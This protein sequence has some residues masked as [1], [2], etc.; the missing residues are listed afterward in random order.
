[1][2]ISYA[3]RIAPIA[4]AAAVAA[5]SVPA[6]A[7]RAPLAIDTARVSIAGTRTSTSTPRR[8]PPS[9]SRASQLGAAAAGADFWDKCR[10][11]GRG[12][13]VR[14]RHPRGLADVAEGGPRQ[15]HAQG[16]QG[17]R[18][19]RTSRS[20]LT[21][22]EPGAGAERADGDRHAADRR[23]RARGRA[24]TSRPS[25]RGDDA[26]RQGQPRAADDRL[27]HHAAEGDARHAEDRSQR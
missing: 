5:S 3:L 9:A 22:L 17:R 18:S 23:R 1:M 27:R 16:A 20:A 26:G 13:G 6:A 25:A 24:R 4:L 7:P 10:Q 11:A 21:R 12:R 19:I 8:R 14:D 2:T 15:E